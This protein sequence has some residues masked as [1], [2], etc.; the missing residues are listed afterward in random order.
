MKGAMVTSVDVNPILPVGVA[1]QVPVPNPSL[2]RDCLPQLICSKESELDGA[3]R[4][5]DITHSG[6]LR[7]RSL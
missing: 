3:A 4:S 6:G 1:L 7:S 2:V 5:A